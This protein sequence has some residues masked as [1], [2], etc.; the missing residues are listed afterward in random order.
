MKSDDSPP[1]LPHGRNFIDGQLVA[2]ETIGTTL[3]PATGEAIGTFSVASNKDVATA[4]AAARRTF[5]TTAWSRNRE[6]RAKGLNQLADRLEERSDELI[7]LLAMENGKIVPEAA[8]E[9]SLTMPKLRYSAAL[10][11]TDTGNAAETKPGAY[12]VVHKEPIGVAGVIVPWNS[13]LFLAAR[14]LGPALAAGCTTVIKIPSQTALVADLFGEI[15]S[16]VDAIPPG[17]VSVF[18][19]DGDDGAK[20][21]VRSP[22]VNVIAYTGSTAVGRQIMADGATTLKRMSLELGGKTP[23]VVFDDADLDAATAVITAGIT[24][25]AGQFCM[26]GSRVLAQSGIADE[27]RQ[28]LTESLESVIVGPS[29]DS[30]SQMGPLID[31]GCVQRVDRVV[32][33]AAQYADVVVRGGPFPSGPLAEGS[34]YR[35]SLVAVTG[36]CDVPIVQEEVFGPVAT[37][38]VFETEAQAIE[39]ANATQYGLAASIW[40]RDVDRPQRVGREIQAGTIWTNNWAVVADQFEEGGFKQSGLGRLNGTRGLEEFQEFKHYFSSTPS[41]DE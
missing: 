11:L 38:E 34:F 14:A 6:Q 25:F 2:S 8:F 4:I 10:A 17:A 13:P 22:D 37:F 39:L 9:V 15:L 5:D 36:S 16:T 1:T 41:S 23:I 3:N 7:A 20:T 28:R 24:V 19:E 33:T 29:S 35:P 40:T 31:H 18:V 30:A 26:T 21:L 32:E 27:L 12:S